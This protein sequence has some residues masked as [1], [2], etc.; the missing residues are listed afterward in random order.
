[1]KEM[2]ELEEIDLRGNFIDESVME[3]LKMG[4]GLLNGMGKLIL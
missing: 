2:E 1:M 3:V 4:I